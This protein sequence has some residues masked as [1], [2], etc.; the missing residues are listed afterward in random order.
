VN[1]NIADLKP[2]YYLKKRQPMKY[3]IWKYEDNV[4]VSWELMPVDHQYHGF[5]RYK[6]KYEPSS[7]LVWS[8]EA[9]T[10][11][12][13]QDRYREFMGYKPTESVNDK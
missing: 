11:A 13:A 10:E 3:E 8:F 9:E 6:E 1:E 4:G 12:Q 7:E 5:L 2:T